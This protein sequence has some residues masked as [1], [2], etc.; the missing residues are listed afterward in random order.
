MQDVLQSALPMK[1][2]PRLSRKKLLLLFLV[3]LVL[4]IGIGAYVTCAQ[5]GEF[6]QDCYSQ[7]AVADIV[8]AHMEYNNGNWPKNWDE[9]QEAY[10]ICRGRRNVERL[11]DLKKRIAIRFDVDPAEL[12]KTP[13]TENKPPFKIVY[14]RNGQQRHISGHEPNAMILQ[15]LK[16]RAARPKTFKYP[17]RPDPQEGKAR[18]ALAE[19]NASW[20]LDDNGYI[21]TVRMQTPEFT[22]ASMVHV[23]DLKELRELDLGYSGITDAGLQQL[24]HAPRLEGLVLSPLNSD[25]G[26]ECVAALASLETLNLNG[27]RVTDK[28]LVHLYELGNLRQVLLYNTKVSDEGV[29][30]LR[31]ALPNCRIEK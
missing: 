27:T 31:Q 3:V 7:W 15:Y 26:L 13:S 23:E 21:T 30:R 10:E 28:G 5:M 18:T 14:L 8:I 12:T 4:G 9:L 19:L 16:E 1:M 25:A 22:D 11:D 29:Q 20:Y 6:F 24:R 17:K 2:R